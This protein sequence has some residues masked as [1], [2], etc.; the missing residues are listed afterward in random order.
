ME[1]KLLGTGD[2]VGDLAGREW[3]RRWRFSG[4]ELETRLEN[5]RLWNGSDNGTYRL[6]SGDEN[7]VL[8]AGKWLRH[9]RLSRW[10]LK[11]T[12]E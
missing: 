1:T 6:G 4:W 11:A 10:G 3:R 12:L 5:W 7:G 8:A 9:E 2:D